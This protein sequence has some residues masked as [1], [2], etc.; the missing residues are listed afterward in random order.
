M[1]NPAVESAKITAQQRETIIAK[2]VRS[3]APADYRTFD[4]EVFIT[5][6]VDKIEKEAVALGVDPAELG[7]RPPGTRARS[8]QLPAARE[9]PT[10]PSASGENR[11][12]AT[13]EDENK[14]RPIFYVRRSVTPKIAAHDADAIA[15][16][17]PA[18]LSRLIGADAIRANRVAALSGHT[19]AVMPQS[20]DEYPFASTLEGGAGASVRSVPHD[21]QTR[22]GRDLSAFYIT[23]RIGMGGRFDVKIIR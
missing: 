13:D 15:A 16:G 20:L 22:Q 10:L 5:V 17:K 3:L 2:L 4:L 1:L 11:P 19:R 9:Q 8:R 7:E 14:E 12:P 21:E 23:N 6:S 18:T